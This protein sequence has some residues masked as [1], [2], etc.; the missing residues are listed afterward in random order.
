MILSLPAPSDPERTSYAV[1]RLSSIFHSGSPDGRVALYEEQPLAPEAA[2]ELAPYLDAIAMR[3]GMELPADEAQRVWA[4]TAVSGTGSAA[5]AVLKTVAA[6]PRSTLV[7]VLAEGRP[8]SESDLS[9]LS[10]LERYLTAD[11]SP[12][13]TATPVVFKDGAKASALR[14]Y[15]AKAYAPLLLLQQSAAGDA[16]IELSGGPF[17]RASVENLATGARK[18]FELKG[19]NALTLDLSRGPLAVVLRPVARKDDT[20]AAVDVGATRG[21]TAEE[22][23]ARERAWDAGQREKVASYMASMSTS[24]RF[25]VAEFNTDLDLTIVGPF[26]SQRGKPSDWAWQEFYLNGVKWKGRTIPKLPI[27]QPEKVTT[28]PLDIRLT[29]EYE[30]ELAGES[31][32]DGRAAYRVE[33]RP[34]QLVTTKPIYRGTAWIDKETFAL[35]RRESIQL[36]LKGDTLSNVQTEYYKTVPSRPD[37]VLPLEIRGEQVFST[38]GRVTA[39]ERYVVM[40]GV[41]INPDD[42]E[43]KLQEMYASKLQMVRDTDE[44]Q[45]YLVPDKAAPETRVVENKLN[46]RSLF[47]LAGAFYERSADYPLPLLGVQYFD[48]D[49]WGKQKQLTVFFGGVLLFAN[50]TDPALFGSRFDLGADVFGVAFPFTE[51]TYRNGTEVRSERIKHLYEFGQVNFGHPIGPYLKASIGSIRSGTTSSGTRTRARSSSLRS[52]R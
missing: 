20:R 32:L 16:R 15:D 23:I 52:T 49:V 27:L 48:F 51:E 26:F 40:S 50:Y 44:G 29:E 17:E 47:G 41:M 22:I 21:L 9:A 6:L 24:L 1:K 31:R 28:L 7:A 46:R 18:D 42:F 35:L 19:G 25:R 38:A 36:N 33:Y 10:R 11:V 30:Y 8:L 34:R 3:P 4:L 37:V 13:P 5:D 12:D 2:Q 14:F 39:I 45:R 43:P